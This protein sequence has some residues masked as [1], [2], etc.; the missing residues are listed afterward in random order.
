MGKSKGLTWRAGEIPVIYVYEMNRKNRTAK[1]HVRRQ[2]LK[3]IGML[4]SV[5]NYARGI[6]H[7]QYTFEILTLRTICLLNRELSNGDRYFRF[8]AQVLI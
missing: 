1:G 2:T 5:V 6:I 3:T 7:F 4:I 8:H